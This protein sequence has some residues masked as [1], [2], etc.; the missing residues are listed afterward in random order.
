MAKYDIEYPDN[1]N[2]TGKLSFPIKSEQE[3]EALQDWRLSKGHKKPKFPDKIG[4]SLLIKEETQQ[5]IIEYLRETYIP[6]SVRLNEVS[7][8]DAGVTSDQAKTLD[9]QLA[10]KNWY[11][12]DGKP[13]VPLREMSDKEQEGLD[14]YPAIS[15]I[16][17]AGPMQNAPIKVQALQRVDG[18]LKIFDIEE[19]VDDGIL[20]EGH[21][22]PN[23]LWWGTGWYFRTS[24]RFYASDTPRLGIT[25]YIQKLYLLPHLGMPVVGNQSDAKILEEGDDDWE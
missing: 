16:R 8:G 4:V 13:N 11:G 24:V 23:K 5:R 22:E 18:G 17:L 9:T 25:G 19:L 15:K 2:V 21:T 6:F 7:R 10:K 12:A 3:I 14:G 1:L 20:P